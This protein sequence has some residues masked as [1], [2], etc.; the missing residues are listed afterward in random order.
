MNKDDL[1]KIIEED[2]LN[3]L[4]VK[5][6]TSS[7]ITAD[8]RLV[9]SFQEIN[10]FIKENHREPEPGKGMQEH[11]LA[12]RL[13]SIREN[14]KKSEG[15]LALDEHGL[16]KNIPKEIS[17]VE[18]I[19]KDDD[20]GLLDNTDDA[21]FQLKNVSKIQ[22]RD[23]ADYVAHRKACKDF[24]KYENL[25]KECQ[26]DLAS[27]KRKILKFQSD[28]QIKENRF[29]VLNGILL[30]VEKIGKTHID[31]HGK[32]DGRTRCIFENGTESGM[33]LRSLG[34]G[35]YDNGHAVSEKSEDTER[36]L[37]E[38]FNVISE[39]DKQ[40][41]FIYIL[42]SLSNNPKIQ[43]L[44][45]LYKIGFSN[46]PVEERIKNASEEPTYLMAPVSIV[47]TYECY[48]FNP[49]KLE[50]LLHNFFGS[51]CLNV[52]IFD[53]K[54]QRHIP[55]EWFIAP[56]PIIEKAIELIINGGIVNYKYD[57]EK[58]LIVLR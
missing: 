33:L 21:L 10:S 49:Q 22:E 29:F 23:S 1:L 34:K 56:L 18:D 8:E 5:P 50:Q 39:K 30:F 40:T 28:Q 15:L 35:L 52:D 51:A 17:S 24:G 42:K 44:Y 9:S 45:N 12:T 36:A 11:Q 57:I 47:S 54:N 32:K 7:V 48:N 3:L 6:K 38:N 25:F 31:N 14:K 58:E 53:Q 46:I 55:R 26:E 2:D 19:L 16:L 13:K 27:G 4:S 20:M 41:G 37:L 43:S